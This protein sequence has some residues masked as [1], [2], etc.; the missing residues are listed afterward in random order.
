MRGWRLVAGAALLVL[1][2]VVAAGLWLSRPL[3]LPL[4]AFAG[5]EGDAARGERVFWAAGCASC[6]AG[7][8]AEGEARLVLAGGQA[9][10]SA[11]G[12]FYAPNVSMDPEH[13]IGG[14]DLAR[15]ADAV[16]RGV[17]PEGAHYYPVFPY[18]A[19]ALAEPGDVADLWAF[20]RTL[21]AADAPSRAHDLGFP[22]NVRRGVGLW[23]R[24]HVPDGWAVA[25]P[26]APEAE[27]GRYL[28]EALAHCGECH[29][30]RGPLQ[31]LDRARWFEGAPNPTG[32][33]RIPAITPDRLTWSEQ[34]VA[35]YLADG[36]TPDFD[37][38]G[39]HMASVIRNLARLPD[40]DRAALAAYVKAVPA[41]G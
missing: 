2:A 31:G 14:W 27:R 5:L 28:A 12:T 21:P 9:F 6:H 34:E 1:A 32:P 20:W 36:F 16:Q 26:L 17:S 18:T 35:Q 23:K 41:G 19:Y 25:G 24:L 7:A 8:E 10:P 3:R 15:F 11:F 29:T 13:G 4:D 39:G 22:F 30:P 37:S 33:G 40:A 38:A